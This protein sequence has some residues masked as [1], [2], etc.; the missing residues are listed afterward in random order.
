MPRR[1]WRAWA[2]AGL[3]LLAALAA[4]VPTAGDIGLTWDEPAYKFSQVRSAD[5]WRRLG[6][7]AR[8]RD[9]L[10]AV[11]HPDALLFYWQY[12][13][14]GINFHPPLAGQISVLT[15]AA[16]G[17]WMKDI[18]ARR[19]ASIIEFSLAVALLYLFLA[20][21]Y[22]PW[23]GGIAA[24]ALL[25]MP[26]VY[27]DGHI[28]GT[29]TPGLL[30]WPL[31]AFAFW[32]GLNEPH[33]R[34][35]RVLVGVLLGLAFVEKMAAVFVLAPLLGWMAVSRLPD[36]LRGRINRSDW[37]DGIL[38][39]PAML[40]PLGV[41]FLE[42]LRI[43]RLYPLP[44]DTDLFVDRP[45]T[46][47][48]GL[49]LA[50]PLAVW[51]VRRLLGRVFSQSRLWGRERP[52]LETLQAVLAFAPVVGW[53]GNPAWWLET[54][55]RLAHYYRINVDRQGA[56]PDIQILYLG[57]IYEYS[58]PWHNGW[59]LLAVTVPAA[60]LLAAAFGLVYALRVLGKDRLPL[61]FLVQL[62]TLPVFRML[63]TPPTTACGC[64]SPR[65]SFSPR[66]PAG[67]P[68]GRPTA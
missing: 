54:I 61:Y 68:S 53:L 26:R 17:G 44:K 14:Y 20:R 62:V 52:A 57:Q 39:L 48:P 55:P 15:R 16:F 65:S 5:W 47:L 46:A 29:D 50:L 1:S 66:S 40:L 41:A 30:L 51:V 7:A 58:L 59:V 42:I 36:F 28:A 22:G 24:G 9:D 35:Y 37:A 34:R 23:V 10:H 25:V 56:L 43:S 31:T 38:T 11:L 8:G 67:G 13:R 6:A 2:S 45:A 27:G 19:M 64:S 63:P 33:A 49:V 3:V 60:T 32:K 4:T 18:P 21:R 12:G